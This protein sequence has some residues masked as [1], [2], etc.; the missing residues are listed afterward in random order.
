MDG[1][2]P[3][4]DKRKRSLS[5]I[6]YHNLQHQCCLVL[7]QPSGSPAMTSFKEESEMYIKAKYPDVDLTTISFPGF[8]KRKLQSGVTIP[9][10]FCKG[11]TMNE[12]LQRY[13]HATLSSLI[14]GSNDWKWLFKYTPQEAIMK[15]LDLVQGLYNNTNFETVFIS[16]MFPRR[17]FYSPDG[18]LWEGR[19]G[20]DYKMGVK[21]FNDAILS[22]PGQRKFEIKIKNLAGKDVLLRYKIIDM[23]KDLPYDKMFDMDVYCQK[24]RDGTH[25]RGV[26]Y[27]R[28]LDN[29]YKMFLSFK[30]VS[31]KK[32]RKEK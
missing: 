12:A 4:F 8:S 11:L 28:F 27:E 13:K 7:P 31:R 24:S 14:F 15:F 6:P 26:Y 17:E 5:Y 21:E 16:T 29:L 25:V 2:K 20:D 18:R 3:Y 22:A 9:G 19:W 23:T 1:V 32:C 30:K 10:G